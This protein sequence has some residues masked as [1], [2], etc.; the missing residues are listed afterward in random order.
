ML[1]DS[2]SMRE[3]WGRKCSENL[4]SVR[5]G[6]IFASVVFVPKMLKE[7]FQKCYLMMSPD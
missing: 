7:D 3:M 1:V 4:G 5:N 2:P 6:T